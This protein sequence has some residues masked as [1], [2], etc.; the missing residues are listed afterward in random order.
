MKSYKL[1]QGTL[2]I[3]EFSPQ[4]IKQENREIAAKDYLVD[5][6]KVYFSHED[7]YGVAE[8]INKKRQFLF[9]SKIL[10]RH[11]PTSIL[12]KNVTTAYNSLANAL[13]RRLHAL[14]QKEYGDNILMLSMAETAT[15]MAMNIAEILVVNGIKVMHS[16]R[17]PDSND[18]FCTFSEGHSHD[19]LHYIQDIPTVHSIDTLV[20]IDD[21]FS[22]GNTL[23]DCLYNLIKSGL[24]PKHIITISFLDWRKEIGGLKELAEVALIEN[25]LETE[26]TE[27]AIS[28]AQGE[29]EFIPNEVDAKSL[30]HC[31]NQIDTSYSRSFGKLI[32]D[33][34]PYSFKS[35]IDNDALYK[36]KNAIEQGAISMTKKSL[37]EWQDLCDNVANKTHDILFVAMGENHY[38][39]SQLAKYIA[40]KSKKHNVSIASITRSPILCS[41]KVR[42]QNFFTRLLRNAVTHVPDPLSDSVIQ[43]KIQLDWKKGKPNSKRYLYNVDFNHYNK[44]VFVLDDCALSL[45]R[46]LENLANKHKNIV[47]LEKCKV[48]INE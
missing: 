20:L 8:R 14:N 7:L 26:V 43:Q 28:L 23:L 45:S 48:E 29:F 37:K 38:L 40:S 47:F 34:N 39:T 2:N 10:G 13:L 21:E 4:T 22:T 16:T 1:R 46:E 44:V 24:K 42:S 33:P 5:G 18:I 17:E 3:K 19:T 35:P 41:A 36:Y 9:V 12:D 6:E 31:D 25:G 32:A 30:D 15:Q 27:Y 11:L